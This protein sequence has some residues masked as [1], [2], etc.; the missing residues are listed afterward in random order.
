MIVHNCPQYNYVDMLICDG[1][2]EYDLPAISGLRID[3]IFAPFELSALLNDADEPITALFNAFPKELQNEMQ[4]NVFTT[5]YKT[6][7]SFD[8]HV[9]L[10]REFTK[11]VFTDE[12]GGDDDTY[13]Y[14]PTAIG[15]CRSIATDLDKLRPAPN[16]SS[17]FTDELY[18]AYQQYVRTYGAVD[19]YF[20]DYDNQTFENSHPSKK[21]T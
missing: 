8:A 10:L 11:V 4:G 18:A 6:H 7:G 14:W 1:H 3:T 2:R 12:T 5:V 13:D 15:M 17:T 9:Q 16:N 19:E 20:W 21:E